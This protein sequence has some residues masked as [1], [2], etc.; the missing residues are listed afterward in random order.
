V[1]RRNGGEPILRPSQNAWESG[2][3]FNAA[4]VSLDNDRDNGD[5]WQ[6]AAGLLRRAGLPAAPSRELVATFYRGRPRS[7]PGYAMNRSHVGLALFDAELAQV[8]RFAEPLLSPHADPA[9]PDYLGV[10]DPRI[11][12]ID[13]RF[14]MVYCG[15]GSAGDTWRATLCTAESTD[16]LTWRKCG[17]MDIRLTGA[18]PPREG[19]VNNKDGVLFPARTN[20]WYHLLHRPMVGPLS[21][22]SIHLARSRSLAG[23]WEDL[24]PILR[25]RP[26]DGWTDTWIG[27]GAVPL[28]LGGGRFLEIY[29]SGHFAADGSRLYTLG[30]AVLDLSRLDAARPDS[31]VESRLDHFMKPQT[32]WEIEGPYPDSVGNVLFTCGAYERDDDICIIYGGGDTYV[33]AADVS[34]AELLAALE[35]SRA[36]SKSV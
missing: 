19:H 15:C 10:E 28:P 17:P 32:T 20:G 1:R 6:I 33:M 16:L 22:W 8:H 3:T 24:G 21:D 25:A 14:V 26:E 12:R 30:A 34:R 9:S 31:V 27:A 11:T 7:D 2:V 23:P 13:G 36:S 35:E 5:P 4:V 18:Q 29:H